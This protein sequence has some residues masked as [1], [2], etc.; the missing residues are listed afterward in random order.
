MNLTLFNLIGVNDF[1]NIS[2]KIN[3]VVFAWTNAD[4]IRLQ[5]QLLCNY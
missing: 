4:R 5:N 3:L 1:G 2:N